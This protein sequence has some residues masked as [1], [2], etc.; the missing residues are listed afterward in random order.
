MNRTVLVCD[1]AVSM[2]TMLSDILQRA[3]LTVVGEASTG[4]MAVEKYCELHPDLVTM[5]IVMPEMS[6]IEAVR[7]ITTF[8]PRARIVMC[9]ALGQQAFVTAAI[10]AGAKEFVVKPFEPSHVL[11]AVQRVL[12]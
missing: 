3:G 1:D 7:A 4:A 8:D 11:E 12:S 9:S 10:R 6:G 2:R 5:D